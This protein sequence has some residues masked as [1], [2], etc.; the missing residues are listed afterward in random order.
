[1]AAEV[2][3]G[4]TSNAKA[5]WT[6]EQECLAAERAF[7]RSSEAAHLTH[8][9]RMHNM[10]ARSRLAPAF[11]KA[12]VADAADTIWRKYIDLH[13]RGLAMKLMPAQSI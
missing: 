6:R 10:S 4:L 3:L 12:L 9:V 8:A 7:V 5:G 13:L 2:A 11:E 1:M